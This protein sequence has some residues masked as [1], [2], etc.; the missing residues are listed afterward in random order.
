MRINIII[1]LIVV[2][3]ISISQIDSTGIQKLLYGV[4]TGLNLTDLYSNVYNFDYG[5]KPFVGIFAKQKINNRFF[6]LGSISYSLKG[7]NSVS[8]YFKIENQYFEPGLKLGILLSN[9]FNIH[10]GLIYSYLVSSNQLINDGQS[11][12]GSKRIHVGGYSSEISYPIGIE[13][14]LQKNINVDL[15]YNITSGSGNKN[16]SISLFITLNSIFKTHNYIENKRNEK[17]K[18]IVQL[19][20]G[21][22]LVRLKTSENK[23]SSLQEK[24][25]FEL[26]TNV[27]NEQKDENIKIISAFRT[28]F[29]FCKVEFFYSSHSEKILKSKFDKIFLNDNLEI[30]LSRSID[31]TKEIFLAEFGEISEN[32]IRHLSWSGFESNFDFKIKKYLSQNTWDY[33]RAINNMNIRL[34]RYYKRNQIMQKKWN[35]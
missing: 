22:L 13:F 11:W 25:K 28:K 4:K 21:T 19:K 14:K 9:D 17:R 34:Y 12:L 10:A 8:P 3:K 6:F 29:N 16:F 7:S 24:G 27:E 18:Q 1:L 31:T 15:S 20:E 32:N 2:S 23:I 30:D 5:T 33:D 35:K 26:A